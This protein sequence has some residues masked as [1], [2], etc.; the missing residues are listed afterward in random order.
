MTQGEEIAQL[1][2]QLSEVLS[3]LRVMQERESQ[4]VEQLHMMQERES[5]H[6][7]QLH[8]MQERESQHLEQLHAAQQRIEELEKQKTPPPA[9]VKP[10]VVKPQEEEKKARKK[11]AAK[12]N[13][14]RRREKPTR[15][16][17]HPIKQCPVCASALG[18]VSVARRRQV[19]ELPPP[20]QME[21]TDHVVYHG[22]WSQC[23][24]W[25]EAPLSVSA[26]VIGQGRMGV[27]IA[28]VMAYLRTVMRLPVRHLFAYLETLH[29]FKISIGEIVEVTHRLTQA[30]EPTLA[31]LKH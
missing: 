25:R 28:S 22:W 30:M 2:K 31:A 12:H 14:G 11:R 26:E 9:F 10:N 3:Q 7:E 1:K 18:G 16:V 6:L 19:I 24:K 13:H 17:E 8:V 29:G 27:K 20:P 5:Q 21:V 23:G 4:H 15:V